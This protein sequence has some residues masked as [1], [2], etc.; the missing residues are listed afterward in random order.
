MSITVRMVQFRTTY[1]RPAAV[2]S[3]HCPIA[4]DIMKHTHVEAWLTTGRCECCCHAHIIH[5]DMKNQT[6]EVHCDV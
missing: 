5:L 2:A 1:L 6:G 3:V 4:R